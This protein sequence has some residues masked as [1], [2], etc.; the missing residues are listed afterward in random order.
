MI[1]FGGGRPT[2][3]VNMCLDALTK[4]KDFGLARE[5]SVNNLSLFCLEFFHWQWH[6]IDP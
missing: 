5:R 3:R 2:D 6:T 1:G 4:P